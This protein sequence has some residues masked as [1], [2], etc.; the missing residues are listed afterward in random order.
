MQQ[1]IIPEDD[2]RDGIALTGASETLPEYIKGTPPS[3]ERLRRRFDDSRDD[4]NGNRAKSQTDRGYYDGPEQLNSKVRSILKSRGQPA[5]YTNRVRP[6][7]NGVLG[8]LEAG[9][10]DP[11]AVPRNPDDQDN[12]DVV[13][14]TL[15]FINDESKFNDTQ[16]D[17]AE[18]F[19]IEGT[20]AVIIELVDEKIT[21][22]QIRW[23]EFY[24]DSRSRRADLKDARYMGIAKWMD[25]D[26]VM[27]KWRVRIN[28]I[29]DPMIPGGNTFF[30]TYEDRG[31]DGSGW[32]NTKRRRVMLVEEYAIEDGEWKRIVYIA[33]GVLEY[34][35]S[36]YMD[37]K[38]RPCCPIE[39]VSCY[40]DR[41][42]SRYGMVRDMVPIQDEINASRSRSLHLMNSRQVTIDPNSY[43]AGV[44]TDEIR[45]E[46]AK[47][48]GV[49][50]SGATINQTSDMTQANMVRN[51]E[52]KGEIE[53]MG[54][55]PAVL[56]RNEG[57]GQSGRARLVSQ[58]A[59]LT[60]LA[61]PMG[62]LYGWVLRC[63]EQM[64]NRARQ[65]WT[66][67]MWIRV[68]D[69]V[70]AP[71]F[72]QVNEPIMGMVPQQVTDPA[73]GMPTVVEMP[74][75]VGMEKRLS[76][77]NMD[78]I[79]DTS[80]DTASLDQ[81]VW[82]ELMQLLSTAGGLGAIFSEEFATAL[83]ISPMSDKARIVERL[84]AK[85]EER[86]KAQQEAQQ[87]QAEQQQAA[88]ALAMERD[89]AEIAGKFA[90]AAKTIADTDK[91]QADTLIAVGVNPLIALG[92]GPIVPEM[93]Q[94]PM[95]DPMQQT[96]I[97]IPEQMV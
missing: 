85:K 75:I 81:E 33:A 13:T 5:I 62:R 88:V 8:V 71:S 22:T 74:G 57:A 65:Y 39:G 42:N 59:G 25:A 73:T 77:M 28:D 69:D 89:Q 82:A 46:A 95:N 3:I 66:D 1:V 87:G 78:V 84:K 47:A 38:N 90:S 35:P 29:G 24:F 30:D 20:G 86:D 80:E 6:A 14:K 7:V 51:Q 11:K 4:V 10:R 91:V 36:P 44:G 52:A 26:E 56:G 93:P 83:E 96:G 76:E 12:A 37:D 68:T 43:A 21:A 9:R 23:E 61:R 15:R 34:G 94:E 49:L 58:Q 27:D 16:M 32:V 97:E 72:L 92:D 31:D 18:N 48:D 63:Y 17:V 64:W 54:P 2:N 40:V 67:P 50:P 19:F 79:L 55:T 53:R 70:E 60:E 45:M 41:N